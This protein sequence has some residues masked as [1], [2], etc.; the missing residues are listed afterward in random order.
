MRPESLG[1]GLKAAG[2]MSSCIEM[3]R[4]I[5]RRRALF[6]FQEFDAGGGEGH[7]GF[8][9]N[10]SARRVICDVEN[11][12][13]VLHFHARIEYANADRSEER[14][15]GKECRSRWSSEQYRRKAR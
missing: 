14:R 9:Q 15:V 7:D 13:S 1:L 3:Y 6:G 11:E 5:G 8:E 12:G 10:G 2:R 4:G